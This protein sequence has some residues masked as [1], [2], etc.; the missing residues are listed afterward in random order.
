[1]RGAARQERH[2]AAD[3]TRNP[4]ALAWSARRV[5]A[6]LVVLEARRGLAQPARAA[7][8]QHGLALLVA[9]QQ[10]AHT[11]GATRGACEQRQSVFRTSPRV[12][13]RA[14]PQL[15]AAAAARAPGGGVV[16]AA[17][18]SVRSQHR[19]VHARGE[20]QG[21]VREWREGTA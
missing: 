12:R 18:R 13:L 11:R 3:T 7:A 19:G 14:L 5:R 16:V 6:C 1:V 10:P 15:H 20:Q 2:G 9:H 8:A 17:H 4:P 21:A